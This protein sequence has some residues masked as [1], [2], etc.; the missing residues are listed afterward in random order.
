MTSEHLT[1]VLAEKVMGWSIG[2]DRFMMGDRRWMPRWRFQPTANLIDAF[3]LLEGA[4][5]NEYS[6]SGGNDVGF[7]VRVR[8]G[9]VTGEAR[10]TSKPLA[11]THAIARAAGIEVEP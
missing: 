1:A 3:Q 4:A 6:M 10:G 2:P 8:I 7:L 5:P 11:I 9:S